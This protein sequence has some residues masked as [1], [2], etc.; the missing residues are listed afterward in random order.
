MCVCARCEVGLLSVN[1]QIVWKVIAILFNYW[2]VIAIEGVIDVFEG[3]YVP[4]SSYY[5]DSLCAVHS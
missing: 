4:I 2:K 5:F 1:G 3:F